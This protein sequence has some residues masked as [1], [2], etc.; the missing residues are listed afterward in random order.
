LLTAA[1][2]VRVDV[3][4]AGEEVQGDTIH[5]TCVH[6][7]SGRQCR[8]GQLVDSESAS[9]AEPAPEPIQLDELYRLDQ[10]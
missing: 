7:A 3:V 5:Y 9:P 10:D 6:E 2:A 8:A 4:V 1:A